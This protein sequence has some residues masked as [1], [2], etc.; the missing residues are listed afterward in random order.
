M[1]PLLPAVLAVSL[2]GDA[3]ASSAGKLIG[4][5]KDG[6][7]GVLPGVTVT[8]SSP[9]LIG[10]SRATQSGPDGSFVFPSLE[11]G[12]YTV[13]AELMGFRGAE[14]SGVRVS[15]DRTTAVL[16]RLELGEVRE[17]VTVTAAAPMV[18]PARVGM[19]Q[20]FTLEFMDRSSIGAD[21]RSY[22]S[23]AGSAPGVTQSE[24]VANPNV[25]GSTGGENAYLIDGLDTTDPFTATFGTNF[26]FDAIQE[27]SL[28]SAGFE[29]EYGRATGG[30]V[31]L[32]TKSGG[33]RFSGTFDVRYRNSSFAE[34]GS[35]FDPESNESS[36][37]LP[38]ATLGGPLALDRA[39]FFTSASYQDQRITPTESPLAAHF[40]GRS[41][42]GKVSWQIEPG[43]QVVLKGSSAPA[44][45]NDWNV[46]R[47]VEPAAAAAERQSATIYQAETSAVLGER[48]LWELR[49]GVNDRKIEDGP[50]SGDL[51]TPG[52]IDQATEL[53]SVNYTDVQS[54]RRRRGEAQTSLTWFADGWGGS[55]ELKGGLSYS[56]LSLDAF[57]NT[58]G[59]A[60]YTDNNGPFLYSV[61]PELPAR[62]Y[63]GSL[64]AGY[65]QDSW[66]VAEALTLQLG[67]RYD[68][69]SYE[70]EVGRP[71]PV[72]DALQPRL[73]FAWDLTGDTRTLL[74]GSY[75]RFMHPSALNLPFYAR[76]TLAPTTR[77]LS[78]SDG[79]AAGAD[80]A[81][82]AAL[83]ASFAAARGGTVV[84]DP[85]HRD[86][87]GYAFYDVLSSSPNQVDPGL[88][89][90]VADE[91]T[92]GVERQLARR[93]SLELS[94][95]YKKT[96]DIL[97]DTCSENVPR[98]TADP[99][100]LGCHSLTLT[101]PAAA[102]RDY[103]GLLLRL[104]SRAF[105]WL[106]LVASY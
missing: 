103:H 68:R 72:L 23:V 102:R 61:T 29:A 20:V 1:L 40:A 91:Y 54:S 90:P 51:E 38:A 76:L 63:R 58:V 60:L 101:N 36:F 80:P 59:G 5:V 16:P 100:L 99:G 48:L 10:G 7:G 94:Y 31:N 13:R 25:L 93:T 19:G 62:T 28:L 86:P 21:D 18:D 44:R 95:I 52:V 26:N 83:C 104:D 78:C 17:E 96:R 98:P 67:L 24:L 92:L 105:D 70:N 77:Y 66:R 39:W 69:A 64:P 22:L 65:L 89:P 56:A 47:F 50:A 71:L 27:I 82:I 84:Q 46:S 42:L 81:A 55:H 32:I 106:D 11:P 53:H 3:W 97:A 41:Y 43:W 14:L 73:G 75:G 15:L 37:L 2:A 30:V 8:A 79:V 45:I 74:R 88:R 12:V 34:K 49:L 9:A 85:L 57:D 35:H 87:Y 6:T 4:T 33:N